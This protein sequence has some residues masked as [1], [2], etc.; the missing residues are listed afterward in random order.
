MFKQ[1]NYNPEKERLLYQMEETIRR[2]RNLN[3]RI[4]RIEHYLGLR[5]DD[6][7]DEDIFADD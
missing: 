6:K 4:R 7:F 1:N 2:L 5:N 3:N